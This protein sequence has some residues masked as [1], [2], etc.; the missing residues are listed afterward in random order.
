VIQIWQGH[1]TANFE[2]QEVNGQGH[3]RTKLDLTAWQRL[4]WVS[5][6]S[7]LV[8]LVFI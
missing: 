5:R 1:E 6:V 8:I 4:F 3:S 7:L 2:G